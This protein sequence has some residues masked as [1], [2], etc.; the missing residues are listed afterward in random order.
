MFDHILLED[1]QIDL[2]CVLVEASRNVSKDERQKFHAFNT[3]NRRLANV[4]HP[5]LPKDYPGAYMGDIEILANQG[6]FNYRFGSHGSI[7]FDITPFGYKYYE[8]V[9]SLKGG[10]T[11]RIELSMNN[12]IDSKYFQDKYSDAFNKWSES[13]KL[14][15]VSDTNK[16]YTIIGHLCRESIQLYAS[17]LIKIIKP[18]EYD[19]DPS[20]TVSRLRAVLGHYREQIGDSESAF[21]DALLDY[22]GTISDLIQRQEHGAQKEGKPLTWEDGRRVVFQTMIIMYEIDRFLFNKT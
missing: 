6:F 19:K 4:I 5:G 17:K 15:W 3:L 14:L 13:E 10:A 9:M 11:E 12:F 8:H 1:E 18:E 7:N 2:L 22:W 21:S 16:Q 20:H